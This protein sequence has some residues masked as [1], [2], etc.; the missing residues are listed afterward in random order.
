MPDY[1]KN[2]PRV[3]LTDREIWNIQVNI[4]P[5]ISTEINN[6]LLSGVPV[7]DMKGEKAIKLFVKITN[8][9]LVKEE[10]TNFQCRK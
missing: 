3:S 6:Y 1:L 7:D 2:V 8:R 4:I 9:L 10:Y 5:A